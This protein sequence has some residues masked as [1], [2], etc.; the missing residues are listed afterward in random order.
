ML[1][2]RPLLTLEPQAWKLITTRE[3]EIATQILLAGAIKHSQ[4]LGDFIQRVYRQRRRSL[5]DALS[6]GDWDDFL[7]ECAHH[8]AAV[9]GW[10][11]STKAKL[12]QVIVRILVE[13]KYL[14][15]G[16]SL[17][18]S[19]HSLHPEVVRYLHKHGESY[20]LDCLERFP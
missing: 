1:D 17:K 5:D 12:F 9:A 8:D 7:A 10:S 6:L 3:N 2:V 14:E 19:P 13:T 20:V 15:T 4:L 18:L 16:R 11:D